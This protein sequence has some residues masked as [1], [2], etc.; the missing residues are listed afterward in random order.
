MQTLVDSLD[1]CPGEEE[2][3]HCEAD[4]ERA[5]DRLLRKVDDFAR[6]WAHVESQ[7]DLADREIKRLQARRRGF[8]GLLERLKNYAVHVMQFHG[9]K[10]LHGDTTHLTLRHNPPAVE[11]LDEAQ[12]PAEYKTIQ[13]TV[14]CDKLAIKRAID[15]GITVP[16]AELR[17]GTVS[18]LRR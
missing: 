2:R 13:T 17:P 16:G 10:R 1:V 5:S 18:L 14:A 9:L 12:V 8:A 11:I 15:T 7:V 4:I 6:F 3:A